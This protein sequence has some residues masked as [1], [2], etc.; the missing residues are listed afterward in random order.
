[1][2][3]LITTKYNTWTW[4][5]VSVLTTYTQLQTSWEP[6]KTANHTRLWPLRGRWESQS[7]KHRDRLTFNFSALKRNS[8][9]WLLKHLDKVFLCRADITGIKRRTTSSFHLHSATVS[10]LFCHYEWNSEADHVRVRSREILLHLLK[11]KEATRPQNQP[12]SVHT[13][14]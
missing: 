12:V 4:Q 6:Q 5:L 1:M 3:H 13:E 7:E 9:L 11:N 10:I 8:R 2:S 14:L